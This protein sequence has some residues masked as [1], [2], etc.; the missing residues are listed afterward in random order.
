MHLDIWHSKSYNWC[1]FK[2]LNI[3]PYW[4]I[5]TF[6]FTGS[7]WNFLIALTGSGM[8][9][10][11]GRGHSKELHKKW[12]S[13]STFFCSPQYLYFWLTEIAP[14]SHFGH[15]YVL[16]S[17]LIL[18]QNWK[19]LFK[20]CTF[21][22]FSCISAANVVLFIAVVWLLACCIAALL[23]S[24]SGLNVNVLRAEMFLFG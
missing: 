4:H 22:Q 10:H 3:L 2:Q 24:T 8:S 11:S 7:L 5:A 20:A 9:C 1:S 12:H 16:S 15:F 13:F 23:L 14:P 21:C 17:G 19:S 18:F 6:S